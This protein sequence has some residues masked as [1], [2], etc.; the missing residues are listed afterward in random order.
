MSILIDTGPIVAFLNK[1]DQHHD[2]VEDQMGKLPPPFFTC[3]A[4][5]TESF[6][7][8]SRLPNGA[9]KLIELLET[10]H[11]RI[12]NV[13]QNHQTSVHRL[14]KNYSNVPMSLADACLV[15]MAEG[16]GSGP[17]FSLD[18]DFQ[19]YRLPNGNPISLISP[20]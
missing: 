10:Q 1:N 9:E 20:F 19:I 16:T 12:K 2:F 8:M 4:V 6:F 14:I 17:V 13:Y 7:L 15:Q 5:L 11:I 18:S 3:E